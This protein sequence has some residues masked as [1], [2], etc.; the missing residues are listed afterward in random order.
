M[1]PEADVPVVQVSLDARRGPAEHYEIGRAVAAFRAE[2][3]LILGSGNIVHNLR[4]FFDRGAEQGV[5]D[6]EFDD[7]I[8]DCIEAGDHD[9]V[10]NHRAHAAAAR[11]APDWDHFF[12]LLP[13]LGAQM[14]GE[15]ARV[16]NRQFF[17]GISMTSIGFG[18]SETPS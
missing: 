3:V 1:Y 2:N 15:Q 9:A 17:P 12:P 16:F 13:V 8:L 11:A 5:W 6:R 4:A 14:D 7:F 18:L 10:M